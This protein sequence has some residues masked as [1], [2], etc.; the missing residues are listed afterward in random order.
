[1]TLINLERKNIMKNKFKYISNQSRF[2]FGFEPEFMNS[3]NSDYVLNQINRSSSNPVHG[4]KIKADGSQAQW[5]M[6]L[7]VLADCQLA[8]DYLK[9]ACNFVSSNGGYVNR[10]CSAHVHLSTLPIRADLTNEEFTRKSIQMKRHS[11]SYLENVNNLKQLFEFNEDTNTFTQLPLEVYKDVGYRISSEIDFYKSTIAS[12][13]WDCYYAR[14]PKSPSD[15]LRANPTIESLKEVLNS[16]APRTIYKYTA[17]N[18]N[19]YFGKKTFENRSHGGTLDINKLKTWFKFLSNIIDHTVQTRFK[20]RTELQQLTSPS[21][22]GRSSNT[23]KSQ[24]WAF[25]RGQVRSTRE[26]MQH[27]NINNAQ[28][29]RRTISEIRDNDHY[30]SFVVT[31]NQQE[32]GV[33]YG[34]SRDHGDNGYEVLITKDIEV[35]TGDIEKI[36]DEN[37]RGDISL[38][39]GLDDQ[40]L[41]DLNERI[42]TIPR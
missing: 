10:D 38:I 1:M 28:S 30:K 26:I 41:A 12:S 7:P 18:I 6:D 32:F 19:H 3:Q 16:H 14:F 36:E 25:C 13:R 15:I 35:E 34:H 23:V 5:E 39:A 42:R 33:D 24:L 31:H 27:C 20:A 17:L 29:V 11:N 8:W 2:A 21:Y 22:I 4:L 9:E 40:T 37:S